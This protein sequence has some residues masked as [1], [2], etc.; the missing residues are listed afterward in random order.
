LVHAVLDN[1][2]WPAGRIG[3]GPE[4]KAPGL[5][6]GPVSRKR[7]LGLTKGPTL[8]KRALGCTI[9]LVLFNVSTLH[10]SQLKIL[11]HANGS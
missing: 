7:A 8:R 5:T 3:P 9:G 6:K 1:R 10:L 2:T 4:K 11:F